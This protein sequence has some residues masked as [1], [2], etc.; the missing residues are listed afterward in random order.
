MLDRDGAG[1]ARPAAERAAASGGAE[2]IGRRGRRGRPGVG[3]RPRSSGSAP[4][5]VRSSIL[6]TSAGIESFDPLLDI[7]PELW[8]R[9]IAVNLTGTFNCVQA[10]VADM[11]RRRAGAASSPS[12]RPAPSPAHP[13]WPTTRRPKA[14]SSG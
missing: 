12:R 5:S 11:L 1:A 3:R 9:I 10:A 13:T 7:T 2:V 14:G 6:V 8:D 4:S